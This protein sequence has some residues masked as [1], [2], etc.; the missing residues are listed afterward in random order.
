MIHQVSL[1]ELTRKRLTDV[2][3]L[4]MRL[5]LYAA[6]TASLNQSDCANHLDRRRRFQGR[7]AD[8][9]AWI[10]RAPKRHKP[11]EDFA[12]KAP[13]EEKRDWSR[14][15]AYEALMFLRRPTSLD[16]LMPSVMRTSP[17]WQ[18]AG[19]T[20]L[21]RFYSDLCS[22]AGFPEYFFSEG[23]ATSFGRQDF[24][25]AF[26]TENRELH[27]CAVCDESGYRTAV[28]NTIRTDIEHYLPK[29]RYPHLACHPFNLLPICHLCN[30][31]K[32]NTDPLKGSSGTQRHLGDILLPYREPGLGSQTYLQVTLGETLPRAEFGQL[33][34]RVTVDLRQRIQA[35]GNVY[36]VPH[37]WHGQMDEIGDKLFRRARQFLQNGQPP[38]PNWKTPQAVL[39]SLDQL[40]SYLY[41]DQGKDR[42]A[43]A[44]TW[45]LATLINQEVEP[46]AHSPSPSASQP[47]A[48]LQE[49]MAWSIRDIHGDPVRVETA[50]NLRRE[51]KE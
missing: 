29:S 26:V 42:F 28:D 16:S 13:V 44:M 27:V 51:V 41:E 24:L 34:P 14:R 37:R 7:G 50:R 47:S 23:D 12:R 32:S 31:V 45:W 20:F 30:S 39:G 33:K 25:K 40:L 17:A 4:Q 1:P 19:A 3:V 2:L 46:S 48:L 21:L 11:L 8:I 36:K 18:K 6:G 9:A 10:W 49:L 22:S 35:F 38:S 5:L 43:F 15:L